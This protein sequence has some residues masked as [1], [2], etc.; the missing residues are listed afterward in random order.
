MVD[1]TLP[2]FTGIST[3]PVTPTVDTLE[4]LPKA[5]SEDDITVRKASATTTASE[6]KYPV[7]TALR[8]RFHM[9]L[10]DPQCNE[11]IDRLID[12]SCNNMFTK[13]YDSFQVCFSPCLITS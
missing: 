8:E 3:K 7:S 10:T 1:S 6:F 4:R 12:S 9:K 13:L 2:C 5:Q 11:L